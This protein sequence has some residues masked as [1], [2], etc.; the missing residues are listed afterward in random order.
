MRWSRSPT[1]CSGL[2]RR[3]PSA[4]EASVLRWER[5]VRGIAE[6]HGV[7]VVLA[8]L[9]G[10][11]GGKGFPGGSIIVGPSGD[12]VYDGSSATQCFANNVFQTEF[13]DGI[14]ELFPC[15]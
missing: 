5:L 10:F 6:E 4:T 3:Q 8:N 15:P 2:E 7:F 11:E 14:T 9:V 13:P 1:P 12:I